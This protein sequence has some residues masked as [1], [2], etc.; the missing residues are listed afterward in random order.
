MLKRFR[1][2]IK[3]E[4]LFTKDQ[5]I[6]VAVSGGID[7]IALCH[8]MHEAGYT[9]GMAHCNFQLRDKESDGDEKFVK[10]LAKKFNVSFYS[11]RF[12]T[13][14]TAKQKGISIQM[15]ARD[16]RYQ[17]FE[18]VRKKNKYNFIAVA[19]HQDDEIETFFI[20]LIRGTGIAGLHGIKA[21]SGKIIRPMMFANRKEIEEYI[22]ENKI[23]FREDSSN[24]S[25]KYMRNKVRHQLIPQLKKINPDV[26]KTITSEIQRIR[27]IES[28]F[29]ESVEEKKAEI[30]GQEGSFVKFD[31]KRLL[32]LENRE[33]YLYEFL[34]EYG[35]SGDII[36]KISE[37][38]NAEAGK[39]YFSTTHRIVKDRSFLLLSPLMDKK[40]EQ[41]FI[42]TEGYKELKE[43]VHLKFKT[44][45]ISKNFELNKDK[46]I[47]MLDYDKLSFPLVVRKWEAGDFFHPFGMKGKK[48]LSD[49]FTDLKLSLFDKENT[50]LLCNDNEIAWIVG[51]R[52]DDRYKI[53]EKTKKVFVVEF[54]KE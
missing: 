39:Q 10:A 17:W 43:P 30:I 6:L 38:L 50:W 53:T 51:Q 12:N 49:F 33:L 23:K 44:V 3:K 9:F 26:E 4:K 37:G 22:H 19:H 27:K 11:V 24:S 18:E 42:I 5:Q 52:I 34:K 15:A 13:D 47:A 8:L 54:D 25:L 40:L 31:I 20:N 45:N 48:K 32:S 1:D 2:F 14:E 16:L 41:Q 28:I 36:E 29:L 46:N 21:M 35:F 7:S